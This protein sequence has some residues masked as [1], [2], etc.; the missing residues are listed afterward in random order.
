[1]QGDEGVEKI[2]SLV[3]VSMDANV[4]KNVNRNINEKKSSIQTV[5]TS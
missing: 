2:L 1:M 3:T 4:L 5:T